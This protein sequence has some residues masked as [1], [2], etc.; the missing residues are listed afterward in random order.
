[1]EALRRLG[2]RMAIDDFGTG[3]SS[4]NYLARFP[5]DT[6]K[7]DRSFVGRILEDTRDRDVVRTIIAM[8][9]ALG[10]SVVAEG[11]DHPDVVRF[12]RQE[13]C[14]LGQGYFWTRPVPAEEVPAL[15]RP[16]NPRRALAPV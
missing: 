2:V 16:S 5:I 15:L 1:M 8:G 12:L 13:G 10:L 14:H 4:L 6:L 9:K 7:I 3:Y 11:V